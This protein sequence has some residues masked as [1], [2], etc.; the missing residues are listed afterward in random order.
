MKKNLELLN[1]SEKLLSEQVKVTSNLFHSGAITALQLAE[2]LNRRVDLIL[3]LRT[4]EQ[5]LIDLRTKR[6][7]QTHAEGI[8]L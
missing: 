1:D 3:N 8:H 5:G 7:T 6:L 4:L 2:V